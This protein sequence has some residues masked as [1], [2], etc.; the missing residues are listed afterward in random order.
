MERAL[1]LGPKSI[2][3][4]AEVGITDLDQLAQRGAVDAF[5]DVE[6]GGHRPS[7]N[8]LYALEG[9]LTRRHWQTIRRE[10]GGELNLRLEMAREARQA[11]S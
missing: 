10:E 11:E 6:A 9:A 1:N 3:W 2:A 5:L 4:L 7:L 8:L